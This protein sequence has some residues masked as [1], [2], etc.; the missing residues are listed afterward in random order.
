MDLEIFC[1]AAADTQLRL[2]VARKRESYNK[3]GGCFTIKQ[4]YGVKIQASS[5]L[6]L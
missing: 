4:Q 1:D 5:G 2:S 6:S 3:I